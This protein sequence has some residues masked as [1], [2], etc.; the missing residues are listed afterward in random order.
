MPTGS[1]DSKGSPSTGELGRVLLGNRATASDLS[2]IPLKTLLERTQDELALAARLL[3]LKGLGR[4]RKNEVA[5][6]VQK[7]LKSLPSGG[8]G[9]RHAGAV[10]KA[11]N[12]SHPTSTRKEARGKAP[13]ARGDG[14]DRADEP[15]S[16]VEEGET[17]ARSKFDLG[18]RAKQPAVQHIPWGYDQNRVTAMVVDPKRLYAYWEVRDDAIESARAALG[19]G[20]KDAWLNLRVYDITG[21]IFDGTNAHSYLDVKLERSDRQWFFAIGKPTSTHCVEIGMKSYEGYFH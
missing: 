8:D 4:L 13:V 18:S 14:E 10:A 15:E 3:G 5:E 12:Q 1:P 17:G 2:R 21:R 6:R 11:K 16:V 20:G 19:R 9:R 7:A